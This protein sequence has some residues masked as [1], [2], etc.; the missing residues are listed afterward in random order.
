MYV[1]PSG[2]PDAEGSAA[3]PLDLTTALTGSLAR[4]GDTLWLQGGI[5]S[6]D[7]TSTLQGR[8]DQP[9]TVRALPGARATIDGSLNQVSGGWVRYW[10]FEVMNSNPHRRSAQPGSSPTDLPVRDA[11]SC[12]AGHVSFVNLVI[13]DAM[14]NG[15][16][17]WLLAPDTEVYG[18]L[19]YYNGWQGPDRGHGHG[20]YAQN[21]LGLKQLTDCLIFDQY[22]NG[23]QLFGSPASFLANFQITGNAFFNNGII[24]ANNSGGGNVVIQG[25]APAQGIQFS[26]NATYHLVKSAASLN[27]GSSVLNDDL[28]IENN[29]LIGPILLQNWQSVVFQGNVLVA[30]A[31]GVQLIRSDAAV[32]DS[33]LWDNNQYWEKRSE[34]AFGLSIGSVPGSL[35]FPD[36]RVRTG[37][38]VHSTFDSAP[39]TGHAVMI[40]PNRYETGRANILVYNW[41]HT[42]TVAVDLSSAVAVGSAFEIRSVQD[43]YGL[44]VLTGT[45]TGSPI[46]LPMTGLARAVPVGQSK[47]P[48]E[49]G[50]EFNAFILIPLALPTPAPALGIEGTTTFANVQPIQIPSAGAA[51][52][53][54]SMINVSGLS[55]TVSEVTVG[56]N[57]FSHGY[58]TDVGVLL[59]SPSGQAALLM[60]NVGGQSPVAAV[61][62]VFDDSAPASL[63][64]I[65]SVQSGTYQPSTRNGG[66]FFSPPAPAVFG[67]ALSTVAGGNPNGIWSLY[68]VDTNPGDGGALAGGWTLSLT[69]ATSQPTSAAT[70]TVAG[71]AITPL[72]GVGQD[73]TIVFSVLNQGPGYAADVVV[74]NAL[75]NRAQ[76]RSISLSQGFYSIPAGG[77]IWNLGNLAPGATA[78]VTSTVA[79]LEPGA[80][81]SEATIDQR[82]NVGTFGNSVAL[83]SAIEGSA[84][85]TNPDPITIPVVGVASPY[86]SSISVSGVPGRTRKVAITIYRLSHTWP[87]DIGV[88]LVA[89]TGQNVLLMSGVGGGSRLAG[90]T[91]D[92]DD[93][94]AN[95]LPSS[96]AI[97]SGIY[98]PTNFG[99]P[100]F[101]VPSSA[102][103][104]SLNNS[105]PNGIWSLYV[106]DTADADSGVITGGWSINIDT[107]AP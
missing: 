25:A 51:N 23:M 45:F 99:R 32:L 90:V 83:A 7:F 24:A 59:V 61:D 88:L 73:A 77:V 96:G 30:D 4:P 84:S 54:P 66:K 21:Q 22:G 93:F 95:T 89:P 58:P 52:P 16:G 17:L 97:R 37:F 41:D 50:P 47:A 104:A 28:R 57:G 86:P 76:L 87:G 78:T 38:D 53:Y 26:Q 8:A 63:S 33:Y 62:L 82:Q 39:P 81:L 107:D 10:G 1:N 55:G 9:I 60:A 75:P 15:F 44:P 46:Q 18:C 103:L 106:I 64:S 20:Y 3:R 98:R 48:P 36:W 29:Y 100:K 69:T 14:G 70:L 11:V 71:R 6:G 40:R 80:L 2:R 19:I 102:A 91:L 79:S 65:I 67:T 105:D 56:L 27:A 12:T 85:F 72:V 35:S 34:A 42:D 101:A 49:T 43:Y 31:S 92:F 13:H 94:S 68:V 74:T 5:Y